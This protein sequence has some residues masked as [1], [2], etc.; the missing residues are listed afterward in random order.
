MA[1]EG[2]KIWMKC[3]ALEYFECVGDDLNPKM[4]GGVKIAKFENISKAK[5]VLGWKPEVDLDEGLE[6]TVAWF[7]KEKPVRVE[8]L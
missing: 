2:Q 3:G 7:T 4:P 6:K 8:T 5:K 1:I